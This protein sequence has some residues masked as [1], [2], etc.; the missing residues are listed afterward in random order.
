MLVN[1]RVECSLT[2][3]QAEYEYDIENT[4]LAF[5]QD[6]NNDE[7]ALGFTASSIKQGTANA[8]TG[9]TIDGTGFGFLAHSGDTLAKLGAK[10]GSLIVITEDATIA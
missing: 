8:D 6:M 9:I 7:P 1:I 3:N 4:F 10:D 5:I 2:A